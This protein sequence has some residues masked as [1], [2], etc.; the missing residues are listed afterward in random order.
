M[1]DICDT[2]YISTYKAHNPGYEMRHQLLS[3]S[4]TLKCAINKICEYLEVEKM[5]VYQYTANNLQLYDSRIM[6]NNKT[7]VSI[8]ISIKYGNLILVIW[9]KC[10]QLFCIT[11]YEDM[12]CTFCGVKFPS[13]IT[14][15][16]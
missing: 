6:H 4:S 1:M 16:P 12:L 13:W 3:M 10:K 5:A 11:M 15:F 8:C 7:Y 14:Y 2:T 9:Y